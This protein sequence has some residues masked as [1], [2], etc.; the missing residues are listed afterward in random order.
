MEDDNERA[1]RER[2][3]ELESQLMAA[4]QKISKQDR[5]ANSIYPEVHRR[6]HGF[7]EQLPGAG[8][9]LRRCDGTLVEQADLPAW[10]TPA[11]SVEIKSTSSQQNQSMI[12]EELLNEDNFTQPA[13]VRDIPIRAETMEETM[14]R[15]Q[16]SAEQRLQRLRQTN[17][18]PITLEDTFQKDPEFK[19]LFEKFNESRQNTRQSLISNGLKL[20]GSSLK[21][22]EAYCQPFCDFLTQN[23]TVFHAVDYFGNKL[24]KAGFKKVRTRSYVPYCTD[25]ASFRNAKPGRKT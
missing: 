1:T 20:E 14:R 17:G 9:P 2:I 12:N 21:S 5:L 18:A 7:D 10:S 23:P 19:S 24:E 25:S 16:R 15:Y 22:P 8:T 4:Q 11:P 13:S 3:A 6:M